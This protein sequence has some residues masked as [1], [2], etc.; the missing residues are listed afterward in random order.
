[1]ATLLEE[2]A[3]SRQLEAL[4]EVARG[5]GLGGAAHNAAA[6]AEEMLDARLA[7]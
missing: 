2:P 4:A 7:S 1:V 6:I 3:R 5:L